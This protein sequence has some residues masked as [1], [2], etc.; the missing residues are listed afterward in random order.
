M[1][2]SKVTLGT[3]IEA[4]I[5]NDKT[6][7]EVSPVEIFPSDSPQKIEFKQGFIERDGYAI[8]FQPNPSTEVSE[9]KE[10]F[11]ELI[12]EFY[13]SFSGYS[14]STKHIVHV[15]LQYLQEIEDW[16][17]LVFGC[18]PDY[19]A[20]NSK[21]SEPN[22]KVS[23]LVETARTAGCHIHIGIPGW[24]PKSEDRGEYV[25]YSPENKAWVEKAVNLLKWVD[26]F[27]GLKS[28]IYDIPSERRQVYGKSG[29][30]R[31]TK[32]GVE[33]RTLSNFPIL[34]PV[35]FSNLFEI[36]K[37]IATDW[38]ETKYGNYVTNDHTE[39]I[40]TIINSCNKNAA[41]DY[42]NHYIKNVKE[43]GI[44][45]FFSVLDKEL[46]FTTEITSSTDKIIDFWS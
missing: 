46:P 38:I 20:R 41:R 43:K 24:D 17:S 36:S 18:K 44:C 12:K 45:N 2:E 7:V 21:L 15:D 3:D 5:I 26:L 1:S 34:H 33:Y 4:F 42:Y 35:I 16:P 37:R 28:T 14:L 39:T 40:I 27:V 23:A 19:N 22:K 11:R 9:V 32:H 25:F 6:G 8:E 13:K 31:F 10:N 30:F 29:D